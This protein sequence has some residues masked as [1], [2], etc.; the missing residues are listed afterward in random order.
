MRDNDSNNRDEESETLTSQRERGSSRQR[1]G[2]V[3]SLWSL[4]L[5]LT[6][7]ILSVLWHPIIPCLSLSS[8]ALYSTSF[9][10]SILSHFLLPTSWFLSHSPYLSPPPSILPSA[11]HSIPSLAICL[12]IRFHPRSPTVQQRAGGIHLIDWKYW[13]CVTG[14]G[15][16]DDSME[17]LTDLSPAWRLAELVS[18][19]TCQVSLQ[20]W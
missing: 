10:L 8:L 12:L 19:C 16:S 17:T 4:S 13:W 2:H 3:L 7:C 9:H 1:R 18:S 20:R 5:T 15:R 14:A 6:L 11:L